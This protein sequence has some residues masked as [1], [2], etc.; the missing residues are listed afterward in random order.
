MTGR[1]HLALG[2]A[3]AIPKVYVDAIIIGIIAYF[4]FK[5][6]FH[7]SAEWRKFK[8]ETKQ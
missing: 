4:G 2:A 6:M 7:I 8:Q 5:L 3:N 1:M